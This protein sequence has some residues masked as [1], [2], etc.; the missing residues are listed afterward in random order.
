M[1]PLFTVK[2]K[3]TFPEY[4]RYSIAL[5]THI[6]HGPQFVAAFSAVCLLLGIFTMRWTLFLVAVLVPLVVFGFHLFA[7]YKTYY[8]SGLDGLVINTTFSE[9]FVTSVSKTGNLK[10]EY[11]TLYRVLE[12]KTNFYVMI[13][14]TQGFLLVKSDCSEALCAFLRELGED[15]AK[16]QKKGKG[17]RAN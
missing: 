2:T 6:T 11:K 14:K 1:K 12:T 15:I 9:D 3:M 17:K 7:M 8:G 4:R 10:V 13:S 16:R 5:Q